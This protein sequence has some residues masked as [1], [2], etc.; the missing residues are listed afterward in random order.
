MSRFGLSVVMCT[1]NPRPDYLGRAFS[2]LR[3]QSLCFDRWELLV[4]DNRSDEPLADRINLDWHPTAGILR[5]DALGLT[6]AR[7]RGIREARGDLLVFVDDDNVLDADY[8]E[9]ALRVAEEKAFLGAWSGQ[10]RPEFETIPPDWTRRYFGNLVLRE[11][12]RDVWSNLPR[13]AETMPCGAGLCVRRRVAENYLKLHESGA[14]SIQ[15][16]RTGNSLLSGGDNDLAACACDVGQGI[17]LIAALKLIHLIP[18]ERI[19][20]KYLARSTEGI[21]FSAVILANFRNASGELKGYRVRWHEP[22][23]ALLQSRPHRQIQFAALRGR[24][25]GFRYLYRQSAINVEHSNAEASSI[26]V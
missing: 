23:R 15:L 18:P 22:I 25:N 16:D 12:D 10:C 3:A 20:E 21:Y 5:E 8:L 1:H 14:R 9:M 7:L 24:R 6:P 26:H 13:L 19:T 11:F 4:I 2:A 17:G